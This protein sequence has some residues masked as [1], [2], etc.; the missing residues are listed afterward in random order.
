MANKLDEME[1]SSTDLC[2]RGANQ[3]ALI[4]LFKSVEAE[5]GGEGNGDMSMIEKIAA[6]IQKALSSEG[7]AQPITKAAGTVQVRETT[8][9]LRKSLESII[10][11]DS[12]SA[13]EKHDM[14]ADSLQQFTLEATNLMDGWAEAVGK[15]DDMLDDE[16]DEPMEDPD[17]E[18]DDEP[19][20]EPDDEPGEGDEPGDEPEDDMKKG[21]FD[22]AT[23]DI[24]KMS[25]ED[26]ATLDA[27]AKKYGAEE[28]PA[29]EIHPDVQKAIDEVAQLRKSLEIK[30]LEG[31]AKKYEVIGKKA[32]EL[33]P[34]LYDLKKAGEQHYNDFIALLDEQVQM[35]DS[36]IFKEYGTSRGGSAS[37]LD[38]TVAE[39]QKA[40]PN[41]TRAQAVVKAFEINPGLDPFTGKAK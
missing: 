9:A 27:L 18:P 8:E 25:P 19:M 13:V 11:D 24:N 29:A 1:I 14:M 30:E 21:V 38:A 32:E 39:L 20:E 35:A 7:S 3:R 31:I 4:K 41:L 34:K 10:A 16:P 36:G 37:D 15:A 6:A 23:I 40:D 2:K 12:L 22:M 26:K 33:A 17:D 28:E 5:E